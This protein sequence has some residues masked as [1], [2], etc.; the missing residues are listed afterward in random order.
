MEYKRLITELKH[1][2]MRAD[3]IKLIEKLERDSGGCVLCDKWIKA[4]RYK[5]QLAVY[6]D[7]KGYTKLPKGVKEE[8]GIN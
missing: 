3:H 2:Q 6:D 1:D 7:Y 4:Q 5:I 8:Y